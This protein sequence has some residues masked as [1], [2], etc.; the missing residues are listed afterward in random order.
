MRPSQFKKRLIAFVI[1]GGLLAFLLG[2]YG[3][4]GFTARW[5]DLK[6]GMTQAEV[7]QAVGAPTWSGKTDVI[8][9]G[10]QPVTSWHY[11]RGRWIYCADFDYAGPGGAPLLYRTTRFK[12]EWEL[13][14]PS[15]WPWQRPKARA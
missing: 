6:P 3:P 13:Q 15:W 1:L 8:G 10:D 5:R 9:V 4:R 11:K 7:R 12:Q 14:L 2:L